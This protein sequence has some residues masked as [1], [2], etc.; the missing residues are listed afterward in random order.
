[1]LGH[2]DPLLVLKKP[3]DPVDV[4]QLAAGLS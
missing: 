3:Y 2:T 1:V 4:L